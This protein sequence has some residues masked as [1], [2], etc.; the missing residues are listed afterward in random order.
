MARNYNAELASIACQLA[1]DG[2]RAQ[3]TLLVGV[4]GVGK[5]Q[6]IDGLAAEME[7]ILRSRELLAENESFEYVT[8]T[9]P[10]LGPD[11]LEGMGVPNDA[12]TV[13]N[14]LPR[15]GLKVVNDAKYG[16]VFG[17]ELSSGSAET[18]ASFMAFAQDGRAGDL[19][20]HDRIARF[21]A[22]NPA[23]CAA[24]GRDLSPPESNRFLFLEN[25]HVPVEDFVDWLRGGRGMLGHIRVLPQGWEA[26]YGP[27]T[28]NL[29]ASFIET[30]AHL[31]NQLDDV[32]YVSQAQT[33]SSGSINVRDANGPWASQ[34]SLTNGF[35]LIAAC[36]S[37]GEEI[38]S[39]LCQLALQGTVGEAVASEFFTW[40]VNS[41]IPDPEVL[42]KLDPK[43]AIDLLP[44]R[45]DKRKLALE[46]VAGAAVR[47][48][49]FKDIDPDDKDAVLAMSR[50]RWEAG[51]AIVGPVLQ[52]RR[53]D[54]YSAG[55]ILNTSMPPMPKGY[56]FPDFAVLMFDIA[57][58]A[59]I[60]NIVR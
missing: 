58:D 37:L 51:W 28:R 32:N 46:Q 2:G 19:K 36:M 5:T 25:W 9:I 44:K 40:V 1:W 18:G 3:P 35:R 27:R 54:A 57:K 4:P 55:R 11:S 16:L 17:D 47:K 15:E 56:E 50:K 39:R 33:D 13:L 45:S 30:H 10:Q 23:T 12:K 29:L 48:S 31:M 38:N 52:E 34:R 14:Y 24:A 41:E 53:D 8:Y 42:L 60:S 59:G 6:F 22:M 26:E 21:F 7:N 43:D 20:V 49:G